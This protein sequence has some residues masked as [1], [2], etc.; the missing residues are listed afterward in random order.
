MECLCYLYSKITKG[1]KL[2]CFRYLGFG[3]V[4]SGLEIQ[5][6]WSKFGILLYDN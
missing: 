2:W 4:M 1:V 5:E 3:L 6:R